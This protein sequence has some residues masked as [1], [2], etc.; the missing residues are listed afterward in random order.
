MCV[1][2]KSVQNP[3]Q[4]IQILA[5]STLCCAQGT[6]NVFRDFIHEQQNRPLA[7][8]T[9]KQYQYRKTISDSCFHF[10][11]LCDTQSQRSNLFSAFEN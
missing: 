1:I 3:G 2:Q 11:L 6:V 4:L 5:G 10:P 8:N 9:N 7:L